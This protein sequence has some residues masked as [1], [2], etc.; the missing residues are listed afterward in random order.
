MG[1]DIK[2][3]AEAGVGTDPDVFGAAV[4]AL[5]GLADSH[6]TEPNPVPDALLE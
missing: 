6:Q 2:K 1:V 5:S 4:Q 3:D